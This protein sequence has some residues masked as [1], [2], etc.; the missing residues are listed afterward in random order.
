F[1]SG[2]AI[3]EVVVSARF[4]VGSG[5]N[6]PF[7]SLLDKNIPVTAIAIESPNLLHALV[8]PTDSPLKSIKDLK[9]S[10]PPAT[11]GLVT[12]SSAEFYFQMAAQMN[13]IQIGKDVVMKNMPPGEQMAMPRG[14]T[15]VV[16]WDPTPAMMVEERKSGK[17]I[18]AI[19]KWLYEQKRITRPLTAQD[20]AKAVDSRFMQRTFAKLGWNVPKEP[21]FLPAGW[22]GSPS[23]PPYPE[24]IHPINTTTPQPFPGQG[25]LAK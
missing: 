20:F 13:D 16:A 5:G 19:F 9:G 22:K 12:G 17:I 3:N 24:Y 8:V 6:F 18:D 4:Q 10:N 14:L 21:P 15:G 2:P 11:V 23:K 25:D 7:T 1:P